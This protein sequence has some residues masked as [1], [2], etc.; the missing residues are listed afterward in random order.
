[1]ALGDVNGDGRPDLLVANGYNNTVSVLLNTTTEELTLGTA[2]ATG[3]IHDDDAPASITPS[4][5]DNQSATINSPFANP[6]VVAVRNAAGDL[7]QGVSVTFTAPASGPSGS[8]AANATVLTDANGL[9]TA[10]P[11]VANGTAG[12]YQVTAT[13]AGGSNPSTAFNLS[14]A[15][16]NTTTTAGAA[17][18]QFPSVTIVPNLLALNQ[19][20][21]IA[22]HVSGPGG[23][24]NQG[25][26]T[27]SVNGHSMSVSVDG[28]GDAT[29]HLT[30]PLLTAAFP[31]S[32]QATFSGPN[33]LPA[34]AT[35]TAFWG[36][37]NALLPGAATF[38]A[39][40]GQSVQSF[41]LGLPLLDFLY[42]SS[43][44]LMEVVFG[45]DV[46]S[47]DF[48]YVGSMAV[49]SVDGV[50]PMAI[51]VSTPQGLLLEAL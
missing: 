43:G 38:A 41:L 37:M 12:S 51:A 29:V 48:R 17:A 30:L 24:V 15:P 33:R 47:W 6:L 25:T 10:P 27:F 31:Q 23:V 18:I 50:L 9:V 13:A 21:T 26:V 8:F 19:T 40:G 46:L 34:T 36:L 4:S 1:V 14:N 45:P 5:G 11:F 39:D 22:V 3:T 42:S 32:I 7:V 2:T 20:E 16:A 35:P 49:I 28:N 44:Q